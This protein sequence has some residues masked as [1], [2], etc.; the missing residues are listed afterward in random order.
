ME[1]NIHEAKTHLSRL[2]ERALAGE[3][4][5]IAKAGRPL[6]KLIAIERRR[7]VLGSAKG[8]MALPPGWDQK[9][10]EDEISEL[11]GIR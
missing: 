4:V 3:P 11:F 10:T 8:K 2:I 9:L 1:V 7:P 6:V 5:T